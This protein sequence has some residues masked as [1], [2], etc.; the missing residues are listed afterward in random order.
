ML[1]CTL[2]CYSTLYAKKLWV[3]SYIRLITLKLAADRSIDFFYHHISTIMKSNGLKD[4]LSTCRSR[5]PTGPLC[6]DLGSGPT[7]SLI[8]SLHGLPS[9]I[10]IGTSRRPCR[11]PQNLEQLSDAATSQTT[12]TTETSTVH[13][14]A[15]SPNGTTPR[16]RCGVGMETERAREN[17]AKCL[18]K[19][20]GVAH[21]VGIT[22]D[23]NLI[24][25]VTAQAYLQT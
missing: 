10:P 11:S 22:A 2:S 4:T 1:N 21:S 24:S 3:I 20:L 9:A 7:T 8:T 5:G 19:K 12:S 17:Q 6:Q 25:Y 14:V 23:N 13:R 18:A 15:R 16:S